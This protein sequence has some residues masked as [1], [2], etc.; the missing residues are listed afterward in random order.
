[1]TVSE[2][3]EALGCSQSMM[4]QQLRRLEQQGLISTR[5]VGTTKQCSLRNRDFLKL[6][7][8]LGNHL[9]TV[10]AGVGGVGSRAFSD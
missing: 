2:L 3:Q 1:M 10:L 9:R 6:F 8:C 7:A 5:K 4:S